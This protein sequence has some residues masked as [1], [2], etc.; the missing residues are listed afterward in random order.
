MRALA[1]LATLLATV[2]LTLVAPYIGV[3]VWCW[4]SFMAPHQL[5]YEGGLPVVYVT[6]VITAVGLIMSREPK[7][8]PANPAPWLLL[9]FMFWTTTTSLFALDPNNAWGA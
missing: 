8:L 3:L 9:L 7:R 5:I 6:A 4:L 2:P 1:L